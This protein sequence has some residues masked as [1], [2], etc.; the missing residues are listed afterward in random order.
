MNLSPACHVTNAPNFVNKQLT[1][2]QENETWGPG[3]DSGEE[4]DKGCIQKFGEET[5][6]KNVL[7][8]TTE[9]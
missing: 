4:H 8:R 1:L 6:W 5:C 3:N 2:C 9:M 7:G